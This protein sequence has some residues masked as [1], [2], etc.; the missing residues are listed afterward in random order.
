M[1]K[2]SIIPDSSFF[3]C[4][5]DDIEKPQQIIDLLDVKLFSFFIGKITSTEI[6]KSKNFTKIETRFFQEIIVYDYFEYGEI[7]KMFFSELELK[8]GEHEVFII[9]F[10]LTSIGDPFVAIIDDGPAK[11]FFKLNIPEKGNSLTGT[12]GFVRF[13]SCKCKVFIKEVAIGILVS[14]KQSKFY[15]PSSIIDATIEDI[16]T[17]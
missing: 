12:V 13:C 7:V 16:S 17:C 4:F 2:M 6:Q 5:L 9:S 14:I 10:I 15:V 1:K 8:K 3:I 11:K